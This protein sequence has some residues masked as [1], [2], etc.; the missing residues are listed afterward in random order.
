MSA[1]DSKSGT[2]VRKE[3][4]FGYSPGHGGPENI[5]DNRKNIHASEKRTPPA[6]F[7]P[8]KHMKSSICS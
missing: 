6:E 7:L 3:I 1:D 2:L 5:N 4:I 8:C